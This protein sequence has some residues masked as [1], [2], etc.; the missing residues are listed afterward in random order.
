[1]IENNNTECQ[2]FKSKRKRGSVKPIDRID[3][4]IIMN[5]RIFRIDRSRK[6]PSQVEP[7]RR[8]LTADLFSNPPLHSKN[9]ITIDPEACETESNQMVHFWS[10]RD[11]NIFKIWWSNPFKCSAAFEVAQNDPLQVRRTFKKLFKQKEHI[12]QLLFVVPFQL[13]NTRKTYFKAIKK[14][15]NSIRF[16]PEITQFGR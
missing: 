5:P 3:Y 1:M 13:E 8:A 14:R 12:G 11:Q 7:E 6:K 10:Q 9:N 16:L 2:K 4:L 15:E